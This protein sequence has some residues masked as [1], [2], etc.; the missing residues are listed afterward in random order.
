VACESL[1]RLGHP[2]LIH[3]LM[4]WMLTCRESSSTGASVGAAALVRP[5]VLKVHH[6]LWQP[7][8]V[9]GVTMPDVTVAGPVVVAPVC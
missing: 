4:T 5:L 9:N 7:S 1:H 8:R 2:R 3:C 6:C